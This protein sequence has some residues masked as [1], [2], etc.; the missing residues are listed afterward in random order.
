MT[1]GTTEGILW[2]RAPSDAI[3]HRSECRILFPGNYSLTFS[4]LSAPEDKKHQ[5]NRSYSSFG[6]IQ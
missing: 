3:V 2:V 5:F 1:V 4:P 6:T